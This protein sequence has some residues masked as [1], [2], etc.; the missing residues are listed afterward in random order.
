VG[1]AVHDLDGIRGQ[2]EKGLLTRSTDNDKQAADATVARLAQLYAMDRSITF[3]PAHDR[4]VWARTFAAEGSA[5][6]CIRAND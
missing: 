1:D 4:D 3:L 6:R 5:S 2:K